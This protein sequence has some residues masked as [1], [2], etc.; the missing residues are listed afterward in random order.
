M[1]IAGTVISLNFPTTIAAGTAVP[2]KHLMPNYSI[3]FAGMESATLSLCTVEIQLSNDNS[4]GSQYGTDV[5]TNGIVSVT[6]PA[7]FLRLNVTENIGCAPTA[8]VCGYS[9]GWNA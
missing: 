1:S 9:P 6:C 4:N 2:I 8:V 7:Q 3:Q 5:T